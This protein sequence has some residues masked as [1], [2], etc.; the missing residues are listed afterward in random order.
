MSITLGYS[1]TTAREA[2]WVMLGILLIALFANHAFGQVA[3]VTYPEAPM[4]QPAGSLL[5][6]T[7]VHNDLG[8]PQKESTHRKDW[9]AFGAVMGFEQGAAYF[10]SHETVIGIRH[11][12]AVEG[13]TWLIGT[14][15]PS[16]GQLYRREL[17]VAVPIVIS[18]SLV[19]RHFHNRTWFFA[20]LAAPVAFGAK[21]IQGGHEWV[22]LLHG[23]APSGS[24]LGPGN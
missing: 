15:K 16:F 19:A 8:A 23:A 4:P 11:G 18:P 9:I 1:H 12:L 14:N 17:L 13:N 2:R 20:G 6:S 5:L 21:H 3:K 10:D 22:Q 7:E 24:E